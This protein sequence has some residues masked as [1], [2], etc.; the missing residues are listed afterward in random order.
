LGGTISCEQFVAATEGNQVGSY[1]KIEQSGASYWNEGAVVMEYV[2][3]VLTGLNAS[4][5]GSHQIMN[6]PTSIELWIRNWC[7]K[8]PKRR[9]M[10]A[11]SA[12]SDDTPGT[13]L[14]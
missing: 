6:D 8:N 1:K 5:D 7:T 14:R 2:F 10:D 3:G 12:F 4:R 13:K 9:I 11:V